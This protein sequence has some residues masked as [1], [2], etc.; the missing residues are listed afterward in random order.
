MLKIGLIG[1][2]TEW[3]EHYRPALEGLTHRLRVA[4]VYDAVPS[5]A[6]QAA[7]ELG[8]LPYAGLR[9]LLHRPEIAAVLILD[10]AWQAEWPLRLA[11]EHGKPAFLAG[12]C[13]LK[14]P[15]MEDLYA[16][17]QEAGMLIVPEMR[18]RATP[19][20]MRLRELTATRLG[21]VES[22]DLEL[23]LAAGETLLHRLASALDWCAC[24]VQSTPSDVQV[25]SSPESAAARGVC[26]RFRRQGKGG[27]PVRADV[28]VVTAAAA[29]DSRAAPEFRVRVACA[30]GVVE[31]AGPNELTW[32]CGAE[33]AHERLTAERPSGE[34]LLGHFA[35]RIVGGLVPVPDLED[36][37]RPLRLLEACAGQLTGP[38]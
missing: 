31:M 12:G 18:L 26:V 32:S 5:R 10:T 25:L 35:R 28:R 21:P 2:G 23:G 11:L 33:T 3:E 4:A 22:V 37:C 16:Q 17:A 20:S 6:A 30:N 38:D 27:E 15:L 24:V 8:A 13:A 9:R 34:V 36:L 29:I 1:L 14:R 7:Q 19:A